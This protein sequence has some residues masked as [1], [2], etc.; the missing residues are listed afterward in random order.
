MRGIPTSV[1]ESSANACM[2]PMILSISLAVARSLR[3]L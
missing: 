2:P 1:A 3:D